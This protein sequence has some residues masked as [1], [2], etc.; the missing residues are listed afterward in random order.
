VPLRFGQEPQD[1]RWLRGLW[2]A[3][4]SVGVGVRFVL[5]VSSVVLFVSLFVSC[6]APPARAE[7]ARVQQTRWHALGSW[8]GRGSR[9]T[10]SFDVT[11]GALRL[12]W[13][14][15]QEVGAAAAGVFRVSLYSAISGRPLQLLVEHE[16]TG[17]GTAHAA[18]D[19]RTSY[20]V[21][22]SEQANWTVTLEEASQAR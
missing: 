9:Q 8:S 4:A 6:S 7:Q 21:I 12:T 22:E 17:A 3:E 2:R 15:R 20:L 10:E 19:P 14:A 11:T 16:G 1:D 5:V 13:Q 18:D